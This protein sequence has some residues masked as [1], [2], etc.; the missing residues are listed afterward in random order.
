VKASLLGSTE[1]SPFNGLSIDFL[2]RMT[3]GGGNIDATLTSHFPQ[4]SGQL[5]FGVDILVDK[6]MV[7]SDILGDSSDI[8]S[9]GI[10]EGELHFEILF[11]P[12]NTFEK[13]SDLDWKGQVGK[14]LSEVRKIYMSTVT[15][16]VHAEIKLYGLDGKAKIEMIYDG[17]NDQRSISAEVGITGDVQEMFAALGETD[18]ATANKLGETIEEISGGIV[19]FRPSPS[20]GQDASYTIS[21]LEGFNSKLVK[22]GL[23]YMASLKPK[24]D[25]SLSD[26]MEFFDGDNA[27]SS[28]VTNSSGAIILRGQIMTLKLVSACVAATLEG[29]IPTSDAETGTGTEHGNET[30]NNVPLN[31]TTVAEGEGEEVATAASLIS[32]EE[33][34][35]SLTGV[36]EIDGIKYLGHPKDNYWEPAW[37]V[38]IEVALE[39][40]VTLVGGNDPTDLKLVLTGASLFVRGSGEFGANAD[41]ELTINQKLLHMS[42]DV[43]FNQKE[44]N[45]NEAV[46]RNTVKATLTMDQTMTVNIGELAIKAGDFSLTYGWNYGRS[47]LKHEIAEVNPELDLHGLVSVGNVEMFGSI[48]YNFETKTTKFKTYYD[49]SSGQVDTIGGALVK[50]GMMKQERLD[51]FKK[52]PIVGAFVASK[53]EELSSTFVR[54][55]TEKESKTETETEQVNETKSNVPLNTTTVA[56][57]E[58]EEVATAASLISIDEEQSLINDKGTFSMDMKFRASIMGIES[59]TEFILPESSVK[60]WSIKTSPFVLAASVKTPLITDILGER[61]AFLN[62]VPLLSNK[63]GMIM[64]FNYIVLGCLNIKKPNSSCGCNIAR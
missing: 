46:G 61:F 13:I 5:V 35:H 51:R 32:E 36:V 30:K 38:T 50:G 60:D 39:S 28:E 62:K 34:C 1:S 52:M 57:G 14:A 53:L 18:S 3:L 17:I 9:F 44:G 55:A 64:C 37:K 33:N 2:G 31:T 22:P 25:S 59:C 26:V 11:G 7:L 24:T 43:V 23:H 10:D 8:G 48:F 47:L 12:E 29:V 58:G 21:V 45:P 40:R 4:A 6:P 63:Y 42:G 27:E 54:T 49:V 41:F 20:A 19:Y 56:E 16:T 15:I